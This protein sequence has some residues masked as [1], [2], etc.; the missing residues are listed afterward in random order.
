MSYT[1]LHPDHFNSILS[2]NT[3]ICSLQTTLESVIDALLKPEYS[4]LSR[5]QGSSNYSR[6]ISYHPG[7]TN[8]VTIVHTGLTP[9]GIETLTETFTYVNPAVNGSNVTNIQ[10]S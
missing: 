5:I 10:Y 4:K 8:V 7:T 3:K 9:L 2:L 6:V 1:K